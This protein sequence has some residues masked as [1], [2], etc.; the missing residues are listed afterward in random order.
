M[1]AFKIVLICVVVLT[2]L[3][4]LYYI[5]M[6]ISLRRQE[7]KITEALAKINVALTKHFDILLNMFEISNNFARFEMESFLNI[8]SDRKESVSKMSLPKKEEFTEN[9]ER[10][11]NGINVIVEQYPELRADENFQKL[12]KLV[13]TSEKELAN[14]RMLYNKN[15]L[16]FNDR[17]SRVP[18]SIVAKVSKKS[19][20]TFFQATKD[21]L[22]H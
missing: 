17:I 5:V 13:T 7:I 14:V 9:M 6:M 16:L 20:K 15:V 19:K 2:I 22:Y 8:V 10:L 1:E 4:G 3:I 11:Y 12:Q 18:L 21:N